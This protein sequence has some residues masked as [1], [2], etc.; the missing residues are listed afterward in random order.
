M[1]IKALSGEITNLTESTQTSGTT[2]HNSI[3]QG[4][5]RSKQ[6]Y[7]FR[8]ENHPVTFESKSSVSISDGD[9]VTCAGPEKNG[10][11]NAM[12]IKN[13]TTGVTYGDPVILSFVLMTALLIAC[14]GLISTGIGAILGVPLFFVTLWGFYK[15]YQLLKSDK[16]LLSQ[17][18]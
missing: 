17:P 18:L 5:I 2:G 15:A 9:S 3:A 1:A 6:I 10:V 7:S 11:L 12:K 8:V 4:R 16:A 14:I 13:E